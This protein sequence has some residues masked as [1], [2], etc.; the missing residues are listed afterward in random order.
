MRAAIAFAVLLLAPASAFGQA[1][2]VLDELHDPSATM[3]DEGFGL[4]AEFGGSPRRDVV[5]VGISDAGVVD[6]DVDFDRPGRRLVTGWGCEQVSLDHARCDA[7]DYR[8]AGLLG[9]GIYE[10]DPT[11][12]PPAGTEFAFAR[13]DGYAGNDHIRID[14]EAP[15]AVE[16]TCGDGFDYV[17][18]DL[19]RTV[20]PLDDCELLVEN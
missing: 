17:E 3:H 12:V 18:A 4:F 6:F 14:P 10:P 5:A 8:G 7:D 16:V 13:V 2:V 15:I 19:E 1:G 20:F 11:Y 9:L